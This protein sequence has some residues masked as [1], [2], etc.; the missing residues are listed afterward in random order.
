L[1]A[2]GEEDGGQEFGDGEIVL[3]V[4]VAAHAAFEAGAVGGEERE[5]VAGLG[6]VFSGLDCGADGGRLERGDGAEACVEEKLGDL[7]VGGFVGSL[8]RRGGEGGI[9]VADEDALAKVGVGGFAKFGGLGVGLGRGTDDVEAG[10]AAVEPEAGYVGQVGGGD[11]GV[12]VEQD[13][14]VAAAG[15]VDEVV[16]IVE[17]AVGG[18][19]GLGVGGVGLDGGEEEGVGAEGMDVVEALG[20]AVEATGCWV[21]VGGR[22]EVEGVHLID[23]GVLPPDVGVHAGANPAGAG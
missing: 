8:L 23:D 22:V 3:A 20:Y 2:G 13:A 14:D 12:E 1:C 19:D 18:F 16:E 15:L 4:G 9:D 17:G 7:R 21:F 6:D 10:D 11:L 5:V